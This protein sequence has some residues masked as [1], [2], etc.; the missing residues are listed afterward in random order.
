M[1]L[2]VP[3][4][5]TCSINSEREI[6]SLSDSIAQN[7]QIKNTLTQLSHVLQLSLETDKI[8]DLFF[9]QVKNSLKLTKLLYTNNKH[10]ISVVIGSKLNFIHSSHKHTKQF[11]LQY[12]NCELG[13]IHVASKIKF[14]PSKIIELQSYI[15]L[16]ILPLKNSLLYTEAI[17]A[18][19]TDALTS[20]GNRLSLLQDLQHH[21]NISTRYNNPLS[22]IFLDID[23]FKKINDQYGHIIGDKVL[24]SLADIMQ[25]LV[26]KSDKLYRFGGEEFVII[27]EHTN[28]LGAINLAKKILHS[29]HK[30]IFNL[31]D[32]KTKLQLKITLSLGIASKCN[33]D[34][35]ES[36]I[37]RA[38]SALYDAKNNGRNQYIYK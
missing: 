9:K 31:T 28:Q 38:D 37:S 11:K 25:L 13:E 10:N 12:Q 1:V 18:T 23:H 5:S 29:I 6:V 32:E 2:L 15:K 14:S 3:E 26:R 8:L 4:V 30:K 33:N 16:L 27:L 17:K 19:R 24:I 21:F 20:L 34:T 22:V 7:H 35:P 36:L